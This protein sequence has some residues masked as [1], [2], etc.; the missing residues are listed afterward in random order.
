MRME[1]ITYWGT[2]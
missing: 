2:S 1:T